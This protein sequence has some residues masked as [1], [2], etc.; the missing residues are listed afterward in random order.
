MSSEGDRKDRVVD[1]SVLMCIYEESLT[2]L[3]KSINSILNQK[4]IELEL[5]L[6]L[7]KPERAVEI[8][9][10]IERLRSSNTIKLVVNERNIG[11]GLSLNKAVE[12]S[13]GR[14]LA[15]AD[16][17]DVSI[18]SR[19]EL[20]KKFLFDNDLDVVG[21]SMFKCEE[22]G[23]PGKEIMQSEELP[24]GRYLRWVLRYKSPMY[25]PTWFGRREVFE[26]IKYRDFRY[27]QDIDFLV[28]SLKGGAR[29]GNVTTPL[30]EYTIPSVS[31][32]NYDKLIQQMQYV[33]IANASKFSKYN[34]DSIAKITPSKYFKLSIDL[35][36]YY[37]RGGFLKFPALFLA[38]VTHPYSRRLV[39]GELCANL[40]KVIDR[41]F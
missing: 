24:S 28:R 4:N 20:Q 18:S 10:F 15:R 29:M 33:Q 9:C 3:A 16:A 38:C 8:K 26:K 22:I 37:F 40:I 6:V 25:H 34:L 17:D 13:C 35:L 30:V 5:C 14:Y 27:A 31:K 39:L 41:W 36:N 32:P 12:L 19:F 1:V 7:D 11:L 21:A 23:K 2:T